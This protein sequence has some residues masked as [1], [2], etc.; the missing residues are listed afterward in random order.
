MNGESS[1]DRRRGFASQAAPHRPILVILGWLVLSVG[2]P[3]ALVADVRP[4]ASTASWAV[5]LTVMVYAGSRLS[6]N[7][8]S[9]RQDF[10]DFF[11]LLFVYIF[12]G[13]APTVQLRSGS[14][15][16]AI[17]GTDATTYG[18][19]AVLVALGLISYEVTRVVARLA[20]E[21]DKMVRREISVQRVRVLTAVALLGAVYVVAKLGPKAF[22][23]RR[24]DFDRLVASVWHDQA[25]S[26][27]VMSTVIAALLVSAHG[28]LGIARS[29][30]QGAATRRALGWLTA[31][32]VMA[33]ANPV[34]SARQL[35][36]TVWGSFV[37]GAPFARSRRGAPVVKVL[38]VV[39]LIFLFPTADRF[40]R[41][42]TSG[43][44]R[45][46]LFDEYLGGDYD[47]FGML[48][49]AVSYVQT[50]G[51]VWGH[52]LLGSL[53]FFVPR[54]F[55]PGKP[56]DTGVLLSEFRG[57]GFTNRS[58]P[59]W[60]EAYINFGVV[61]VVGVFAALAYILRR[62]D[63]A[64]DVHAPLAVANIVTAVLPPYL[65]ILL[66][67]S[68]LQA[69]GFIAV[70]AVAAWA[71]SRRRVLSPREDHQQPTA[72]GHSRYRRNGA[73]FE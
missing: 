71:I 31:L 63:T 69:T 58:A 22:S 57:Y 35:F 15:G 26:A 61:G 41:A 11:F 73:S 50:Y 55:W 52:Q 64:A 17:E 10:S 72:R 59:L 45:T 16:H 38:I 29:G 68:L 51:I 18:T 27:I 67:G 43:T 24:E 21:R 19:A 49:N 30:G 3:L 28:W 54:Q 44:S 60:A 5:T 66:R 20:R 36:G 25:T 4:T 34:N 37:I 23:L 6:I 46:G 56:V 70:F 13:L 12:M 65:L 40:R 2:L 42:G 39:A 7:I 14:L 8:S 1:S 33:I 53:L 48:T 9:L 47:A 32:L 62:I